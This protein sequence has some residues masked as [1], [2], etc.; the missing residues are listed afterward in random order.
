MKKLY[1]AVVACF[2]TAMAAA[3]QS[4]TIDEAIQQAADGL[5]GAK[6][7]RGATIAILN[8]SSNYPKVSNYIME[9]LSALLANARSLTVVDRQELDLIRREE[10]FQMSGAVSDE[11][12]QSIGRKLGAQSIISG[13]FE[14]LGKEYRMR[15]RAIVVETAQVQ[16]VIIATVK[17]DKV[18]DAL[19]APKEPIQP[20]ETSID[21]KEDW[22]HKWLYLG[23]RA[24]LSLGFYENGGGL[25]DTSIYL[26][27]KMTG[28]PAFEGS[29][30]AS[31]SIWKL[32]AVQTEVIITNDSFDLYSGS[33]SIVSVSYNSLMIPLLAKV[34]YRPAIF[35]VQGYTGAYLSLPLGQMEVKHRNGSYSA[36]FPVMPG[37]VAGGGFGVKLGPGA[38]V[39]DIRYAADFGFLSASYR[40]TRDVSRR[41]TVSFSLGYEIGLIRK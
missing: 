19:L 21:P 13:S 36:D 30:Y 2:T 9:E 17:R 1:I 7:P 20:A 8:I 11:T 12:A 39:G 3:Q 34:Q 23:A 24:G 32:F 14:S 28:S 15:I 10:N 38:V 35:M 6:I 22:K 27:Q 5:P 31:V 18:L 37:F 25:A 26:S 41:S 33:N 4:L 29:L 16:G 40:G